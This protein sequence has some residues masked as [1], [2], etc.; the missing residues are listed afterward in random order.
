MKYIEYGK[1]N[2][3]TIILLHGGGLSW[4]NYR[5]EAELLADH[6]HVILPILDGHAGSDR[7]F[8]SIKDNAAEIIAFIDQY[9]GGAAELIGGLSL[10]GQIAIEM[11][12]QRRSIARFALIESASV[13]PDHFTGAMIGPA[14][15]AGMGLIKNRSFA[16]LQFAYLRMNAEYFEDYY[17]D[18][19]AITKEDMVSFMRESTAYELP[20]S[21]AQ[22][23]AGVTV[24]YGEKETSQIRRSAQVIHDAVPGSI[25][26]QLTGLYHGEFSLNHPDRYAEMVQKITSS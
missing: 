20:D 5:R 21:L 18:T 8:T 12:S 25:C 13:I 26:A 14:I 15:S 11:L 4:W 22:C 1:E 6:F 17:C 10:G 16:K 7:P 23:Q 24:L 9:A 3:K 2:D 19:C